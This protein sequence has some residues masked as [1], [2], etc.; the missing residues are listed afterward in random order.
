MIHLAL[1]GDLTLPAPEQ[2][3]L[4]NGGWSKFRSSSDELRILVEPSKD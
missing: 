2:R 4:R 3:Q 1:S